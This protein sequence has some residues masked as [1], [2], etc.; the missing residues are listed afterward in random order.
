MRCRGDPGPSREAPAK[1]APP[2]G[3]K[4]NRFNVRVN[5][6]LKELLPEL[7]KEIHV[8]LKNMKRALD[9]GD[10]E[11]LNRLGHGLKGAA[12]SYTLNDLAAIF[13]KIE[14]AAKNS[15]VSAAKKHMKAVTNYIERIEI[16]YV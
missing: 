13:L 12:G 4:E 5:V 1:E 2:E 8:E 11:T 7:F 10:F 3:S 6:E 9:G 15:D 16:E 14:T